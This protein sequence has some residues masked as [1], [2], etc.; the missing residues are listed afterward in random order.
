MQLLDLRR[1]R[2]RHVGCEGVGEEE[3][4]NI[5][6]TIFAALAALALTAG[7]SKKEAPTCPATFKDLKSVKE[8]TC[9]CKGKVAGSVWGTD[10]YTQDSSL[11][12]AAEH[13]G[14]I[15]KKGGEIT[16]AETDGCESYVGSDQN[17]VSSGS[18]GSY[19]KSFYFSKNKKPECPPKDATGAV[20]L[21]PGN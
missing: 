6:K 12:G 4:M 1:D 15:G 11:C 9:S 16:V 10:I 14:V 2:D 3:H 18:W 8:Q 20:N 13:A 21:I 7:C 19:P 17:G 5:S